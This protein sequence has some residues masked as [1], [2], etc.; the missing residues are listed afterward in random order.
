MNTIF[1]KIISKITKLLTDNIE[2]MSDLSEYK[3]ML[4]KSIGYE[5]SIFGS[6]SNNSNNVSSTPTITDPIIEEDNTNDLLNFS[7]LLILLL[8]IIYVFF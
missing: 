5:N 8:L 2:N 4:F 7:I 1:K 3:S 6:N